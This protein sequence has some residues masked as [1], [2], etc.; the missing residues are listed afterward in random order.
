LAQLQQIMSNDIQILTN[1][2]IADR[3]STL[4]QLSSME[5]ANPYKDKAYLRA[6]NTIR[7]L[8]E[9]VDELVRSSADLTM[10]AGI[11]EAISGAIREIV[12]TG[13]LASLEKL[14]S[15]ASPELLS[16]SAHPR[17]DP[18]RVLRIFKKLQIS[19]VETLHQALENGA[20]EQ[21]FGSRM[22]QHVRQGLVQTGAIHLYHAHDLVESIEAYLLKRAGVT[23]AEAVGDYRR[24]VE[25]IEELSFVVETDDFV[26]LTSQME[27]YGGR[28]SLVEFTKESATFALSTGP[29]S[30][31]NLANAK[32]WGLSLIRQTG[33]K[34]HLKKL[35]AVS[36]NL[37]SLQSRGTFPSEQSFTTTS[38][39][40]SSSQTARR[41]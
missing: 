27:R 3:L 4:A 24:R 8:G 17:L 25:V 1:A 26:K 12:L 35:A 11:G 22:S 28:T 14:R 9:S 33:S 32:D 10:Y 7:D 29:L 15:N 19:S 5:K 18:K 31:I 21:I 16:I 39:S 30:R 6:A 20:I 41:A 13:T 40:H 34:A 38:V 23:R 37:T 2:E 36:G